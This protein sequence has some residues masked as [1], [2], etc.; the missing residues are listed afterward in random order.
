MLAFLEGP[1]LLVVLALVVLLFGGSKIPQLARSLGEAQREF[2]KA[3]EPDAP[4]DA[5][6]PPDAEAPSG[7]DAAPIDDDVDDPPPA[8]AVRGHRGGPALTFELEESSPAAPTLRRGG[9]TTTRG[10]EPCRSQKS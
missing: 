7:S 4:P 6:P 5:K 3:A 2:R 8:G 9:V 10:D 1:D